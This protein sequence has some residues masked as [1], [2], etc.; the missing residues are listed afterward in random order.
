MGIPTVTVTREGFAPVLANAFAGMGFPAEASMAIYPLEM[1]IPG[2]DLSPIEKKMDELITGLT[3]WKPKMEG[4]KVIKPPK[5]IVEGKDYEDAVVNVNNLFLRNMWSEGLPITPPTER[6]VNWLLTGTDLPRDKVV[7]KMLPRGGIVTVETIAVNLAMAGGR[8]E[9]MPVLIAAIEAI[10]APESVHQRMNSTTCSVYP[11]VVVNGPAAK[12]I[13]VGSGYGCLGPDPRHPAGA[14]IGRAIRFLLQ[15]AGGAIP[16]IGTMSIFGGP[17]RYTNIVFA[18]DEDNLPADWE[19]LSVEQGFPKGSN[20]VTTYTVAS[21]TNIVG[22]E[23][24]DKQSAL[25]TLNLAASFM[26]IPNNNYFY[27]HTY[28]PEGAAGILLMAGGTAQ[29]LS[30][31]GWSKEEVKTYLWENSKVPA[32]KL[33]RLTQP[34]ETRSIKLRSVIKDPMPISMSP[35]GIKIAVAGGMQSGHM[36]WLQVG[37]APER[38]V[39]AEMRFPAN[40]NELLKKAEEDLGLVPIPAK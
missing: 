25:I 13:R 16:A 18:E 28:N 33:A 2:S 19:P 8:P 1:F 9:Y 22:G 24:G 40:W 35:K 6:R 34:G 29:G 37:G 15:G 10:G 30:R 11:V 27:Q 20:T 21:S 38:L 5:I 7:A 31:L 4:K 26:S 23:A 17:A 14:S 32:S 3:K 12:Q 39:S 36:M